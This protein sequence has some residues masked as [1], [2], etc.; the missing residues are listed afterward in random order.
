VIAAGV[1]PTTIFL[2]AEEQA[3]TVDNYTTSSTTT[4]FYVEAAKVI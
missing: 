2:R 4:S 1:G 3:S